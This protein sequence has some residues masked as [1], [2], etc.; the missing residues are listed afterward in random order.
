[1]CLRSEL[2]SEKYW[3][4]DFLLITLST[5]STLTFLVISTVNFVSSRCTFHNCLISF[6]QYY[7]TNTY[8]IGQ[9]V[10]IWYLV[11]IQWVNY[12]KAVDYSNV[13]NFVLHMFHSRFLN[14]SLCQSS[15][16]F[17][18]LVQFVL[19]YSFSRLGVA[20]KSQE[21]ILFWLLFSQPSSTHS[22]FLTS[23]S[24][25]RRKEIQHDWHLAANWVDGFF[26][27]LNFK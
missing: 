23:Y 13:I 26:S 15:P 17:I 27:H 18:A 1:M 21:N 24:L 2:I 19:Y 9:T 22:L 5:V 7:V 12:S 14:L 20:S 10:D 16:E 3:C 8:W 25:P 6:A 4:S 11:T